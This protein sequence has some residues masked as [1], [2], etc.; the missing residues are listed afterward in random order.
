MDINK[1]DT[2]QLIAIFLSILGFE[3]R[4][5]HLSTLSFETGLQPFLL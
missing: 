3:L 5:L 4:A 1:S 2:F